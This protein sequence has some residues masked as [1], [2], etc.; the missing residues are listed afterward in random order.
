MKLWSI[1]VRGQLH[2]VALRTRD[3][4]RMW[5]AERMMSADEYRRIFATHI[6]SERPMAMWKAVQRN[7]PTA[8][9]VRVTVAVMGE[10]AGE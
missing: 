8:K 6:Y 3:D 2:H 9:I 4:V 1:K 7:H 5:A 10:N